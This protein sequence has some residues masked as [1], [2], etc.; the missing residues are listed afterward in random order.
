MELFVDKAVDLRYV[1]GIYGGNIKTSPF[2][3]LVLKMLQVQPE[4]EIVDEFINQDYFKYLRAV[5]A[6]YLRLTAKSIDIWKKLEPLYN[7]YRKLRIIDRMGK[8]SVITM[9]EYIDNLLREDRYLDVILPRI[10]KRWVHEELNELEPKAYLIDSELM[11]DG[12]YSDEELNNEIKL[13]KDELKRGKKKGIVEEEQ[14][15]ER[16]TKPKNEEEEIEEQNKLRE[17]LG[18]KP[19]RR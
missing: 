14:I 15:E 19:L 4:Q 5:G 17:K 1:G 7:D 16:R 8:F 13:Y 2:I 9:D 3:C 11:E 18:L 6:F 10:S 12:E